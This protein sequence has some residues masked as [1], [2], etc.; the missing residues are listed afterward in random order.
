MIV[1]LS[2]KNAHGNVSIKSKTQSPDPQL[3]I[4]VLSDY[5]EWCD[6]NND[7][8]HW[9]FAKTRNSSRIT[10]WWD[11][12]AGY[13]FAINLGQ[14]EVWCHPKQFLRSFLQCRLTGLRFSARTGGDCWLPIEFIDTD[15]IRLLL[16]TRHPVCVCTVQL[17]VAARQSRCTWTLARGHYCLGHLSL[18]YPARPAVAKRVE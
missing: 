15:P 17:Q 18:C 8:I 10:N 11:S 6:T 4:Y 13:A 12:Y 1:K 3:L 7:E 16:V 9:R 5:F 14:R 2:L